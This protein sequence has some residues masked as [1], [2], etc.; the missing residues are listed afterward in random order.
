MDWLA[1]KDK[2]VTHPKTK[3]EPEQP[4]LLTSTEIEDLRQDS[5]QGLEIIRQLKKAEEGSPAKLTRSKQ[6]T[7]IGNHI[8]ET[9]ARHSARGLRFRKP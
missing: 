9:T 7:T 1:T 8:A 6:Q 4:R 2:R 5:I 3:I